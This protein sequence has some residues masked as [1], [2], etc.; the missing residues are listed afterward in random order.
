[1]IKTRISVSDKELSIV[2]EA[3]RILHHIASRVALAKNA[4]A[5]V[6]KAKANGNSVGRKKLRNDALIISMRQDGHTLRSIAEYTGV[7]IASVQRA[8]R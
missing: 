6:K 3:A 5:S 2:N 7:S 8:L 4:N 1:M